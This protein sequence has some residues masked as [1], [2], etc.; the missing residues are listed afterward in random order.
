[1]KYSRDFKPSR[2][3]CAAS[4]LTRYLSSS[5]TLLLF[6]VVFVSAAFGQSATGS[7]SGI[8]TDP[9]GG[10]I[11][12]AEV[13]AANTQTGVLT[14]TKTNEAG[15]YDIP[16]LK[17]GTYNVVIK[18]TGMKEARITGVL[19]DQNNISRVDRVLELGDVS[20]SVEVEASAPLLQ[21]ESTTYDGAVN[22]KF[23]EDL[24]VAFGSVTRDPTAL[25]LLVPGVVNGT[26]Y[27][28]QFGVNIGG[29]RQFS[30]EFQLDGMAV[31]YQG[32]T[33]NVPLDS[34]P[35]QDLVSEV[36]VQIG[37]PSAEYGRTSSGVVE[38]LT[39]SGTNDLHG[40]ATMLVKNTILDARA[41]N[42][43]TV[44][45][46]QQW[47]LALS[48]G[49]PVYIPKVY[50]GRNR[51]FFF[52]NYT[53]FRQAPG[54][55][56]STVT[57]PTTQERQGNFSDLGYPIYDPTTHLPFPGNII[58]TNR[59]S[60]VAT[61]LASLYPAPTNS[62]LVNNYNGITPTSAEANHIFARGDHNFTDNN[63][64]SASFRW[65]HAPSVLAEGAPFPEDI[66]SNTVM[67]GVQQVILS[68]DWVISPHIVNH[69]AVSEEGFLAAQNSQPLSPESWVPI[70]NSFGPAFPSF[71]FTTNGYAGIGTGLGNCAAS[72]V[73]SENDRSRD[74]Q[75]AV[76][77]NRGTHTFK[78]GARYLWF[79][80]ASNVRNSRNGIY[81][82]SQS[83]TGQVITSPTGSP[84]LVPGTGNSFASFMLGAIDSATMALQQ[85]NRSNT[86]SLGLYAQDVWKVNR[87]LTVN[88]GLRWDFQTAVY[89]PGGMASQVDLRTPNPGAG[90]ILGAYVFG[91][92]QTGRTSFG[93]T[94]Y[95]AWAPRLG[96]AYTITPTLVARVSAGI[97]YAP[98][99]NSRDSTGYSGS[100]SAQTANG[101]VTPAFYFDQGWPSDLVKHPPLLD[102]AILNGQNAYTM[103]H[104]SNQ[105]SNTNALQIDI[106]KSFARDYIVNV[107]YLGQSTHHLPNESMNVINQVNPKYL[108]LGALL[109]D[110]INSPAVV[111][112]GFAPPYPGFTGNLAQA[113]KPYPQY[114]GLTPLGDAIGNSSYNALLIKAEKRFSSG[115]Q[116][117]VS[118]TWSKTLTDSALSAF[119]RSGP[120]DTFNRK[121]EKSLS[122]YDIPQNLVMS[123]TYQLPW[124]PGGRWL[125][126]GVA[127]Q[128]LGGWGVSGILNYMSGTP[129]SVT[130]P[131]TLPLGSSRLD[132]NY[133]GGAIETSTAGRGNVT[134]A[135]G[136]TGQTGTVTLNRAAFGFPDPFTFGN[137]FILPNVRTIGLAS[138]N[139][140]LFK[141]QTFREKYMLELRI[142]L[143]NAF[144]RKEFGGLVTDLTNPAF[145]QY[146][147]VGIGPRTG[148]LAGRF[149]F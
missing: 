115:F 62:N 57:I 35:D 7:I 118:Y 12:A 135:N 16:Y 13:V 17:I 2:Q 91:K 81:E 129:I 28:S 30:T 63:R 124:G 126:K 148:Q 60:S 48:L 109:N 33:A 96:L 98:P 90:N 53:G 24:P 133:L 45:R 4:C 97:L 102:P 65:Q 43:E 104:N 143:F 10:A 142:E 61:G 136:L 47:E 112:A 1:M 15:V 105:W 107:G 120:Q 44:G 144:N 73:N 49:G 95:G 18:A 19:V 113:L 54:G 58:P 99:N 134:L 31:A 8:I 69:F 93:E 125:Q 56:P 139:L 50:H 20:Q 121:V 79:Q 55:N 130:A 131:N 66:A 74:F 11:A 39:R 145:G 9:Q 3:S 34:R 21:Q 36:K 14:T 23:V 106:Q 78:F 119:G 127:S 32:V 41:Y 75:D 52:F 87:K 85:P 86:Q 77:W 141:R 59:L 88:Y 29:G 92:G 82:F 128:I 103:S 147:G 51:T 67:K 22:R 123:F 71:C 140:A 146:T 38:Y 108:A 76:S 111:A 37:V 70:P 25:A 83:E 42:A 72:A 84:S 27:G 40:N 110:D 89:E 114:F 149:V 64:L 101:G 80:A 100:A 137:T 116:Y 132:A 138:E 68:D 117:L 122:P 94:W 26:T 6:L 5:C 46:D